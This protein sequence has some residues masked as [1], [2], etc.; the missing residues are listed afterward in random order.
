MS[1]YRSLHAIGPKEAKEERK[2]RSERG[3]RPAREKCSR[4][5]WCSID[6]Y[7]LRQEEIQRRVSPQGKCLWTFHPI[8]LARLHRAIGLTYALQCHH[9]C[10]LFQSRPR[11]N[12]AGLFHLWKRSLNL[13]L[14]KGERGRS[15]KSERPGF[16]PHAS[17]QRRVQL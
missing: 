17:S 13:A 12:L 3:S 5:K 1:S 14:R 4:F 16:K 11:V 9:V 7:P 2:K 8:Y 10:M 6:A 15:K